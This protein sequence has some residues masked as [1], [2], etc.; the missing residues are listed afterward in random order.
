MITKSVRVIFD[1]NVWISFLIGKRLSRIK[2]FISNGKIIIIITPQ[3]LN[4]I[5]L[6]TTREKLK[7]YFPKQSVQDLLDLLETVGELIE[8]KPINFS[9]RDPKDNFLLDLIEFSNANFL[10]T[11]DKDLLEQNPFKNA[12]ILSPSDF[13]IELDKF[14]SNT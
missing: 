13:E 12:R 4:E 5:E 11:S 7:K 14:T 3:L 9:C 10:I 6:V 8:I 1:T 2:N